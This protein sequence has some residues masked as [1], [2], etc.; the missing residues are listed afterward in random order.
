MTT[1]KPTKVWCR[2]IVWVPLVLNRDGRKGY[3]ETTALDRDFKELVPRSWRT[4]PICGVGRPTRNNLQAQLR[5]LDT[6]EKESR[7]SNF[8]VK[9]QKAMHKQ[10]MGVKI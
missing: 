8:L 3:W 7:K 1:K 5:R 2:H 4:C 9:S 10:Y 6:F